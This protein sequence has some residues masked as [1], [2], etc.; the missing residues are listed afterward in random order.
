MMDVSEMIK[1]EHPQRRLPVSMTVYT[2]VRLPYARYLFRTGRFSVDP[3]C[4]RLLERPPGLKQQVSSIKQLTAFCGSER[5]LD[6][7]LACCRNRF[8]LGHAIPEW[9]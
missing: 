2:I 6:L 4:R 5:A 7:E 3:K 1:L 8:Y 9:I